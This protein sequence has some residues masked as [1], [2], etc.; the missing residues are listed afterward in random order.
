MPQVLNRH[1]LP[2]KIA[3]EPNQVYVG[4]PT[5]WGNPFVIGRDGDR[6]EVLEK[7]QNHLASKPGLFMSL[8]E[9]RGKD[10]ICW[11]APEPCHADILLVL[12]NERGVD[13]EA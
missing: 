4:R 7:Y 3:V 8:E 13:A 11:C 6:H 5:K 1:H 2:N 10:L 12:A 9:L